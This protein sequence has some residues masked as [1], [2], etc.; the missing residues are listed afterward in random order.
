MGQKELNLSQKFKL[1]VTLWAIILFVIMFISLATQ[2]PQQKEVEIDYA[3]CTRTADVEAEFIRIWTE[4]AENACKLLASENCPEINCTYMKDIET[5]RYPWKLTASGDSQEMPELI[6]KT[7]HDRFK[8]LAYKY[9][10]DPSEIWEVENKY[11]I[12]EWLILAILIAETSG[13]KN[14]DYVSEWC[15][16]L[17]NVGNNDRWDRRCYTS[18]KESIEAI[19]RALSNKY[20]WTT[21]TL[22]CLSKAWS[23]TRWEDKWHVYASSGWNWERTIT[24]VLNAIYQEELWEI[25]PERFNVR[26]TF[27]TYQ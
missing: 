25:D 27:T 18:K 26:R 9:W 15:Y 12:R 19:G 7:S 20:L 2:K 22:G 13:W 10:L 14:W 8:E 21:Q 23:C 1:W 16:N 5:E 3:W 6:E 11:W 17:W 4:T 24:N